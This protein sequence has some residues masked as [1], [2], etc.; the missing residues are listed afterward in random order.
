MSVSRAGRIPFRLDEVNSVSCGG[1]AGISNTFAS[2]LWATG[3]IAEAM[4]AGV[5]G[6]NLQGNP[7]NCEGY[8]PL[9]AATSGLL[10]SGVLHPQP[11]WYA[12]LLARSLIGARPLPTTISSP[13]GPNVVVQAFKTAGGRLR[14]VIVDDQPPGTPPATLSVRVGRRYRWAS[15]LSLTAPMPAAR[16]GITLGGRAVTRDGSWFATP[17]L[18]PLVRRRGAITL[19]V[20]ASSAALITLLRAPTTRRP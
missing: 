12:L 11:E 14:V 1:T 2:A 7:A 4:A 13:G 20:P 17:A 10:A 9:C 19:T 15:V 8:S 18:T 6:I 5:S 3:Y 16:S